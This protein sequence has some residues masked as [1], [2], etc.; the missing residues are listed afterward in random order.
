MRGAQSGLC[1][2]VDRATSKLQL[3]SRWGRDNQRWKLTA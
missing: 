1:L 3:Y 2:D